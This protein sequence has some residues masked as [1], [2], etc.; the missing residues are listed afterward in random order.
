ML[1]VHSFIVQ[2]STYDGVVASRAYIKPAF[3]V[4]RREVRSMTAYE[5]ISIFIGILALM[6]S[7]GTL[8]VAFLA[9]LDKRNK[10]K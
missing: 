10:K 7:F 5:I 3:P 8:I 1:S 9:F 6:T 2:E 4:L